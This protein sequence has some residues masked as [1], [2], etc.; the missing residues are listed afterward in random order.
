MLPVNWAACRDLVVRVSCVDDQPEVGIGSKLPLD[1]RSRHFRVVANRDCAG[2]VKSVDDAERKEHRL[3]FP[4]VV[5]SL[6]G[7]AVDRTGR[8]S[9]DRSAAVYNIRELR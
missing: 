5:R 1:K 4:D 6:T 9:N 3:E 7:S 8:G 2:K